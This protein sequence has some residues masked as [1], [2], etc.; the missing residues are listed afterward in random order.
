METLSSLHPLPPPF[1]F[2]K[3]VQQLDMNRE[4]LQLRSGLFP[5]CLPFSPCRA[6][7]ANGDIIPV[8]LPL[9]IASF[10]EAQRTPHPNCSLFSS[11]DRPADRPAR[12]LPL[13]NSSAKN[14]QTCLGA[15]ATAA[16]NSQHEHG[17]VCK[18]SASANSAPAENSS[19]NR[20]RLMHNA[21]ANLSPGFKGN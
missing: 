5:S 21:A 15:S 1:S 11:Q 8:W 2:L 6:C 17:S 4:A 18:R 9:L 20:T 16:P 7:C 3:G 14:K 19:P 10:R 13:A 12:E